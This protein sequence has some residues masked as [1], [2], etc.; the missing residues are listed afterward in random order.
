[1]DI[2]ADLT[3]LGRTRVAVVSSGCK[4]FL[5]IPRTLEFLETQGVT[6]ATFASGRDASAVD[7]P[8]FWARDSGVR[9]PATFRDM[10]EAAYMVYAQEKLG[11]ETGLL[12]ATPIPEDFA[13]PRA[14][15]QAV[16]DRAIREAE[17]EGSTG[18][19]NTP[20]ILLKIK[21]YTEGRSATANRALVRSNVEHAA[22]IAC[23]LAA[24]L[25]SDAGG[26]GPYSG[27][28]V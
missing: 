8:A 2:S 22:T 23:E 16:I 25:R 7:F 24:L 12:F 11:I 21:E 3:E 15:M 17:Q 5:D 20:F 4:G 13:I 6:V 27:K 19:D 14:E 28:A 10:K 18:S 9:S 1:M 26:R